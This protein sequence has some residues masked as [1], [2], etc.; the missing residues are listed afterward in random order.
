M[1]A[2]TV[3]SSSCGYDPACPGSGHRGVHSDIDDATVGGAV[4]EPRHT[5]WLIRERVHDVQIGLP[6]P[7]ER[8]THIVDEDG[9]VRI[10]LGGGVLGHQT[11]LVTFVI[12][13]CDDPSVIHDYTQPEYGRMLPHRCRKV[14]DRQI[15]DHSFNTHDL[16]VA[17]DAQ[18]RPVGD[19]DLAAQTEQVYVNLHAAITAA[20]GSFDDIA[21]LTI[22]IV[23]YEPS[24][25][26]Q[27]GE[28]A[29]S[30]AQRL[31][32]DIVRPIALLGV[33]ALGEPDLLIEVEAIAVLS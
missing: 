8:L 33:S 32:F 15:R 6:H 20:G 25:M 3:R 18:G 29:V 9:D 16:I 14:G 4:E 31:G 24:T 21:N 30:A 5:P 28:G 7:V 12:T 23:D 10:D 17:D 26:S 27:L 19:G 11:E 1:L 2:S 22:Y 13:E